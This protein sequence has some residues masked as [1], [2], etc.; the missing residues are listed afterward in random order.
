MNQ[1]GFK[2]CFIILILSFCSYG[3]QIKTKFIFYDLQVFFSYHLILIL[4]NHGFILNFMIFLIFSILSIFLIEFLQFTPISKSFSSFCFISSKPATNFIFV[5]IFEIKQSQQKALRTMLSQKQETLTQ[6]Y[7]SECINH[8]P[9]S[10]KKSTKKSKKLKKQSKNIVKNI[11]KKKKRIKPRTFLSLEI[12]AKFKSIGKKKNIFV[13]N[14]TTEISHWKEISKYSNADKPIVFII[15]GNTTN[16]IK[17]DLECFFRKN[18]PGFIVFDAPTKDQQSR[19][20]G[21]YKKAKIWQRIVRYT[22]IHFVYD[23]YFYCYFK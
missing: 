20:Y 22:D 16:E 14:P 1:I 18:I 9:K 4:H 10:L 7:P 3:N 11:N 8:R 5:I 23:G 6:L 2:L 17:D 21:S 12:L 13:N 15:K 19:K